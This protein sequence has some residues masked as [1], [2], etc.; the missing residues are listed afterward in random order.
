R[1]DASSAVPPSLLTAFGEEPRWVDLSWVEE[2]TQLDMRNSRFREAVADVASALHG[3]S[4]DDLE[5]EEVRQH[6]RTRRTAWTAGVLLAV[7]ALAAATGAVIAF[8]QRREAEAQRAAAEA[9]TARAVAAESLARSRELAASAIKVL[10]QDPELSVLLGL[11]AIAS[12]PP[13]L[14]QPVE[15]LNA[16]REGIHA[17]RLRERWVVSPGRGWVTIAMSPEG[18]RLVAVSEQEGTVSLLEADTGRE[19]WRYSDPSTVDSLLT[20]SMA[21]DGESIAVG[22]H[23]SALR[24]PSFRGP[25]LRPG[26]DLDDGL[27]ARVIVLD[28]SSGEV[29]ET[30]AYPECTEAIPAPSFSPDGR[31]L[32]I[33]GV[34]GNGCDLETDWALEM[35][36]LTG[37]QETH[38]LRVAGDRFLSWTAD[39]STVAVG[40]DFVQGT[41]LVEVETL[42]LLREFERGGGIVSPDGRYV[43]TD[44]EWAVIVFDAQTGATVDNITGLNQL[45]AGT[46]F[47]PD[48]SRLLIGTYGGEVLVV[49]VA[50]GE[51]LHRLGSAG[52]TTSFACA[53]GCDTLYTASVDGEIRIWDLSDQA[54]GEI[55]SAEAG[56]WINANS[57]TT[58]GTRGAFLGFSLSAAGYPE[59]V[60]FDRTT[61][62]LDEARR[63]TDTNYPTAL[64]DGRILLFE[65]SN[66]APEYGPVVAWDPETNEIEEVLGCWTSFAAVQESGFGELSTPACEDEP[67][68]YFV[69]TAAHSSPDGS[70][71]L[72]ASG[73]GEVR[74]YDSTTLAETGKIQL[75]PSQRLVLEY[76]GD[77]L[78]G[79]DGTVAHVLSATDGRVIATLGIGSPGSTADISS[80]GD[81]LVIAEF[82]GKVVAHSTASWEPLTSFETLGAI[83]GISLSPDGSMLLTANS[84]DYVRIWDTRGGKELHR[85]PLTAPSDGYWLDEKHI[86]VGTTRGLWTTL[87]LDLDELQEI[88]ASR[89]TRSFTPEECEVY[90]IDPCPGL[91]AIRDR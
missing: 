57:I 69:L 74:I 78:L 85:I 11:E 23:D 52:L 84:D 27:P 63:L 41:S 39:G 53:Q 21:P 40:G 18:S 31:Y 49:D 56:Y 71:V 83:R 15:S 72:L 77:W 73:G 29:M 26:A 9:E 86:V 47:T 67:G 81:L 60:P 4:K 45:V 58:A 80:T 17:S 3:V 36:A 12:T 35:R 76:G 19:V 7:L 61:G 5:S 75:P 59:V 2:E 16:L 88:G 44:L 1:F 10:D 62:S 87:T 33:A 70:R 54:A 64:P 6:R 89:L 82:L 25:V 48:G 34:L 90:R 38:R 37:R 14:P 79:T 22:V 65:V 68:D 30:I 91:E 51:T 8:D 46:A 42:Q 43:A 13:G 66:T 50:S 24:H 55:N 32:A 28:A 20:V